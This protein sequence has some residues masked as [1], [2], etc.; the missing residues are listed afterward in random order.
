MIP[1]ECKRLA[2]LPV[3]PKV[4]TAQAGVDFPKSNL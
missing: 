4:V 1:K 3:A 2:D